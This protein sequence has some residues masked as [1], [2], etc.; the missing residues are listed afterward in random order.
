MPDDLPAGTE[1]TVSNLDESDVDHEGYLF[2]GNVYEVNFI[3][4]SGT[5][6][7]GSFTLSLEYDSEKYSKDEVHIYHLNEDTGEWRLVGG[8]VENR[9]ITLEVPHFSTYGVLAEAPT[10]PPVDEDDQNK[11]RYD[12]DKE[13]SKELPDTAT[14]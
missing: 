13:K 12:H 2:V 7:T 1:V 3:Y 9:V 11:G 14:S 10:S 5:L 6:F 4:S 8:E